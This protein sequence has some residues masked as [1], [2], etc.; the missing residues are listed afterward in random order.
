RLKGDT[1]LVVTLD[2]RDFSAAQTATRLHLDAR[3]AHAHRALHRTLH[4]AAERDTLCELRGDVVR[5][6][7]RIELG[8]LALLD[9][10]PDFLVRQ[11][12]ELVAKLVHFSALL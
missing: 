2:A 10:D 3:G 11:V 5:H 8:T 9:V 1:T 7:L 6:Q 4:R 12:R